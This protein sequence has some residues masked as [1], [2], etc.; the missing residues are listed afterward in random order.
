MANL[1]A[2]PAARPQ[3]NSAIILHVNNFRLRR[4]RH[5][6]THSRSPMSNK[7]KQTIATFLGII[8]ALTVIYWGGMKL[9]D[10]LSGTRLLQFISGVFGKE[11]EKDSY[12]HT[13]ILLLGVGGE[14]HEG[15]DLTDTII[16]VSLSATSNEV[17]LVSLPRDLY[18]ESSLGGSRINRLYEKSMLK[19]GSR[20]ALDFVRETV[21]NVTDIEIPYVVKVDFEAFEKIVDAVGGIDIFVEEE[22]NDPFYPKEGTY[23]YELFFLPKGEQHLDG[24]TTLKYVRSRHTT[25]DFDR[26]KRQQQALVALKKKA[27]EQNIF[28]RRSLLRQMYYALQDHVETNLSL[29]ELLTLA[30]FGAKWDSQKLSMAT[31]NDEP[32]FVGGFLYTPVRELYGGAYVLLPAGDSFDSVRYFIKLM[33]YGPKNLRDFPLAVVN[34]TEESGL[35]ARGRNIINRFG[36]KIVAVSNAASVDLSKTTWRLKTPEAEGLVKFLQ[37]LIPGEISNEIPQDYMENP[38]F[39]DAKIILE[40]G[41]DSVPRIEKLDIF[42]NVVLLVPPGG[43]TS[44]NGTSTPNS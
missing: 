29:R 42:K 33:F 14:G 39:S 37:K 1:A 5:Q 13:N 38:K 18:V 34:G 28:T 41:K 21:E 7:A 9:L 43:G 10:K 20:E 19:W 27:Q 36:V 6:P 22:I 23:D 35:A 30:D 17:A 4:I 26:S 12:G 8:L 2:A 25:S 44:T 32:V 15:K 3:N 16:M 31:L 24:K 11:L 40:L